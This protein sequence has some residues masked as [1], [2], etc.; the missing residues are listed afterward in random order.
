MLVTRMDKKK[1]KVLWS[2]LDFELGPTRQNLRYIEEM[3]ILSM[4]NT[5]LEHLAILIL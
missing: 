5:T 4:I 2:L 3:E 1:R